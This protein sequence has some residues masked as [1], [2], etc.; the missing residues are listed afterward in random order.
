MTTKD[1][2]DS[3]GS[4]G[5]HIIRTRKKYEDNKGRVGQERIIRTT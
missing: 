5:Q 3:E 2:N 4:K 1:H